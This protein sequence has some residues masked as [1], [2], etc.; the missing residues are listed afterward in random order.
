MTGA[1][2]TS[3]VR[4]EPWQATDGCD[5]L[6]TGPAHRPQALESSSRPRGGDGAARRTPASSSSSYSYSLYTLSCLHRPPARLTLPTQLPPPA[7]PVSHS[8]T[9]RHPTTLL[10]CPGLPRGITTC[11]PPADGSWATTKFLLPTGR[12]IRA[13]TAWQNCNELRWEGHIDRSSQIE[14]T[15]RARDCCSVKHALQTSNSPRSTNVFRS[16][17]F[18]LTLAAAREYI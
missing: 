10:C 11:P 14:L 7:S 6:T 18:L 1:W 3:V 5:P 17:C 9:L 12:H 4:V 15:A 2:C 8:R 13:P 16:L